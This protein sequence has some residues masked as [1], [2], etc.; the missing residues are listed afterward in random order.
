M[1]KTIVRTAEAPTAIG[2]YSQAVAV[3]NLLFLS[4][5]IPLTPAT[6]E[7]AGAGVGIQTRQ[8][9]KNIEAI[10]S[11]MGLGF[12]HL[13]KTTIYLRDMDDFAEVNEV[14]GGFFDD[15]PPARVT[16]QVARLP[17]NVKVEIDGIAVIP[18]VG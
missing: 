9:M 8:V 10:L 12:E 1:E 16:V 3:G 2:A 18:D 15:N 17:L 5:Q 13:V 14:Y 7:L 4:G 11:A 6:G